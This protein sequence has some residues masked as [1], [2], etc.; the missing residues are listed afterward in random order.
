MECRQEQRHN[1]VKRFEEGMNEISNQ[2]NHQRVEAKGQHEEF[3]DHWG[4]QM[5]TR[6]QQQLDDRAVRAAAEE[7][8]RRLSAAAAAEQAVLDADQRERQLGE[9]K[10]RDAREAA[11]FTELE[12]QVAVA[13]G[14]V[15]STAAAGGQES[16][17][18]NTR[19]RA[20]ARGRRG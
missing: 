16:K 4:A 3:V 19:G 6:R 11:M 20:A 1:R 17:A 8:D 18:T 9:R 15:S 13:V 12:A 2:F 5:L 7:A 10:A 14:A